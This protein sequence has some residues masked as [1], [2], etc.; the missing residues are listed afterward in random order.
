MAGTDL[1]SAGAASA[2]DPLSAD[3]H[4]NNADADEGLSIE[5][6]ERA[7][8]REDAG[9]DDYSE[10]ESMPALVALVLLWLVGRNFANCRGGK[11]GVVDKETT[12]DKVQK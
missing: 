11:A 4:E 5:E 10:I 3:G 12:R 2:A 1:P 7:I 9:D 6:I 8:G